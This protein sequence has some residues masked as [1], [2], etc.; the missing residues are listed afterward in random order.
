MKGTLLC[1]SR[2]LFFLVR[3]EC[4]Q[5]LDPF[6]EANIVTYYSG[7]EGVKW[8]NNPLSDVVGNTLNVAFEGLALLFSASLIRLA[9]L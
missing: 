3:I 2:F 7:Y 1:S 6:G 5:A 8:I 4:S 9:A